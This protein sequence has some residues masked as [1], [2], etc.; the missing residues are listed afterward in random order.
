MTW[1]SGAAVTRFRSGGFCF[2]AQEAAGAVL[3]A[4]AISRRQGQQE[5]LSRR[6][7]RARTAPEASSAKLSPHAV[8][9][10]SYL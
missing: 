4:G 2:L 10:K 9:L 7:E 6:A 5:P 8:S 1:R 3:G